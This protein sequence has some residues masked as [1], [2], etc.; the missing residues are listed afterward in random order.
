MCSK[1][2]ISGFLDISGYEWIWD[3]FTAWKIR[4]EREDSG[5]HICKD[6][7]IK[8]NRFFFCCR[9]IYSFFITNIHI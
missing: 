4:T 1:M 6:P 3:I 8:P 5:Y 2:I 7:D 9:D